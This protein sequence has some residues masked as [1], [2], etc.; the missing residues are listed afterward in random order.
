[1]EKAYIYIIGNSK[2]YIKVGV[3][4]HPK[5]RLTQLQTAN[6]DKLSLL[7]TEEFVCTRAHLLN[8]EK[9]IHQHIKQIATHCEG[10]WFYID[11]FKLDSVKNTI[12]FYRI[13]YED[14]A[15]AFVKYK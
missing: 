4:K 1:M 11:E 6:A 5:K 15:L 2:N 12:I 10:E 7:F 9:A 8:I 14:D 3:S 13:R